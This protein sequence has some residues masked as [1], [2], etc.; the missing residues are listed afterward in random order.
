[1]NFDQISIVTRKELKELATNKGTW[2]SA[3]VFGLLFTMTSLSTVMADAEQDGVASIDWPVI[4]LSMFVGVFAGFVIC[5]TVFFREKQS[6][7]IETLLCT[8]LDLRTIWLGKVLGVALPSYLLG[9]LS[10]GVLA[11]LSFASV[12]AVAMPSLLTVFHLAVVAPLFIASAIGLVGYVQLAMGMR[13]NRIISMGVF[14]LLIA[15]LSV[16]SG[17]VQENGALVTQIVLAL[18]VGGAL[19]FVLSFVLSNRL[20]KEKIVTSIPD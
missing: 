11:V 15:G 19:L 7:V 17:L 3:L 8:P 4:Y 5:G 20:D 10:A 16:S 14:F 9:L 18:L 12:G 1:M 6:G 13:E 2:I